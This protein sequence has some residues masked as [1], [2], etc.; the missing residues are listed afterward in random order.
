MLASIHWAVSSLFQFLSDPHFEVNDGWLMMLMIMM[1]VVIKMV[2]LA[3]TYYGEYCICLFL[4]LYISC[5]ETLHICETHI[6]NEERNT[7][8]KWEKIGQILGILSQFY[9]FFYRL[10]WAIQR[11]QW[12]GNVVTS[13]PPP[14]LGILLKVIFLE[15]IPY[16][17]SQCESHILH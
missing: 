3:K 12:A 1:K 7:L 2:I 6:V 9:R 13:P 8:K 15:S 5:G 4:S 16:P 17:H 11:K 14:S 10:D